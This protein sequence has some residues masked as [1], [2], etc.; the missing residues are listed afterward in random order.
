MLMSKPFQA[1]KRVQFS[2]AQ[3]MEQSRA[4]DGDFMS[5]LSI[6]RLPQVDSLLGHR[7]VFQYG[8]QNR[9]HFLFETAYF[10]SLH[11]T[12]FV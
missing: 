2:T 9:L 1:I 7:I 5:A 3:F 8:D 10:A 4:V 12:S 11:S 6:S